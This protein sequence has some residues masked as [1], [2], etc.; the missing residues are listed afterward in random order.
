M[1]QGKRDRFPDD[2]FGAEY[3]HSDRIF[4]TAREDGFHMGDTPLYVKLGLMDPEE[5][6][7]GLAA[8]GVLEL[9][10]GN[11]D[12]GFGNGA[13]DLGFGLLA[14]YDLGS[15]FTAYLNVDQVFWKSPSSFQ[16]VRAASVTHGALAVE[17]VFKET[18]SMVLQTNYQTRPIRG[19]DLS[20][21]DRPE[22]SASL[23]LGWLVGKSTW[24]RFFFSEGIT[25]LTAPDFSLGLNLG[26]RF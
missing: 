7:F 25:T 17:K 6:D 10:T 13:V 24:M 4:F 14:E 15:S 2:Q 9:P 5:G 23:G 18:F 3:T 22:W 20:N 11:E 26:V 12:S 8:R 1:S 19:G 21:F 16:G